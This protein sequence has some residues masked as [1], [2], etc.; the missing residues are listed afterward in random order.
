M[1][2]KIKSFFLTLSFNYQ[3]KQYPILH[4]NRITRHFSGISYLFPLRPVP[5]ASGDRKESNGYRII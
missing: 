5:R 4:F 1:N 3:L 2:K